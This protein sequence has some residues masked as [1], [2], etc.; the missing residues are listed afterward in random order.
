[1]GSTFKLLFYVKRNG[2]QSYK[3]DVGI[4]T[5]KPIRHTFASHFFL[6]CKFA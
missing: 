4:P 3:N 6:S 5:K 1:M 2:L